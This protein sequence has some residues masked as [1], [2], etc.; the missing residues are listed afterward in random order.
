MS[1][2]E[3][4]KNAIFPGSA[5]APVAGA[6]AGSRPPAPATNTRPGAAVVAPT[7]ATAGAVSVPQ[8]PAAAVDVEAVL[9]GLNAR[10]P[11]KLN[12]RTSIIDLMK[13]VGMDPSLQHREELAT[14]LGYPGDINDSAAMNIWLHGAVMSKL[15]Q[16]GG[17]IP[18]TL[19]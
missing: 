6:S 10:S 5:A 4:L 13:L 17:K 8:E 12:W 16:N 1:L 7:A 11:Q 18:P 14:E 9:E 2:F 15:A 3:T 19:Q